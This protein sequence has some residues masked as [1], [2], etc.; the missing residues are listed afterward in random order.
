R[1][2][3]GCVAWGTLHRTTDNKNRL[4]LSTRPCW[5]HRQLM[6]GHTIKTAHDVLIHVSGVTP[7][8]ARATGSHARSS[9]A[10]QVRQR[11]AWVTFF[12]RDQCGHRLYSRA[13]AI[14]PK[15]AG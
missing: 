4:R 6:S 12:L 1:L 14:G 3:P 10:S 5:T 11:P 13:G 15:R 9:V 8:S 2:T 7:S